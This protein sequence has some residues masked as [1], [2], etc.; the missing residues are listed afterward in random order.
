[1]P[2][3]GYGEDAPTKPV[4]ARPARYTGTK[5]PNWHHTG[6]PCKVLGTSGGG[7]YVVFDGDHARFLVAPQ[8]I[9]Y[10]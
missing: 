1:M 9:E 10:T 4:E 3:L 6:Q 2:K 7:L 8:D 5:Y